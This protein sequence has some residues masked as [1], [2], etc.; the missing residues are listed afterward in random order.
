MVDEK[1]LEKNE[2]AEE[3][4]KTKLTD[5]AEKPKE[6]KEDTDDKTIDV[7]GTEPEKKVTLE[8]PEG[9]PEHLWDK[10]QGNLIVDKT[11]EELARQTKIAN[12]IRKKM[13][14]GLKADVPTKAE[15]YVFTFDKSLAELKIGEDEKGKM[16]INELK[17]IAFKNNMSQSQADGFVND[18]LKMLVEKGIV[19][20]PLSEAEAKIENDKF[21][22]EQRAKLGDNA[23]KII[24]GAAQFIEQNFKTGIFSEKEKDTL[25]K[26]IDSGADNILIIDKLRKLTGEPEVPLTNMKVEGLPSDAE[27]ARN[28]EAGKYTPEEEAE[29]FKKRSKA[30]RTEPISIEHFTVKK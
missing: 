25:I 16:V 1:E 18:Y 17:N 6:E 7:H 5:F 4:E 26:F 14:K 22:R 8:K 20:K 13:S 23:D 2:E 10:E 19:Q 28:M 29:I 27:I 11:V 30:G 12:D 15:D 21:I 24:T 9:L 3:Q